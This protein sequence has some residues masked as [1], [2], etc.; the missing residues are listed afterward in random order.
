[1]IQQNEILTMLV[2]LGV[3]LYIIINRRALTRIPGFKILFVSFLVLFVGLVLTIA[4]GFFLGHLM[5][6]LEHLCYAVSS[7]LAAVWC[8]RV[9]VR[10]R[11]VE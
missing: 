10:D 1:M 2:T 4:E 11:G 5:N 9:F 3:V 8:W 6:V 7:L